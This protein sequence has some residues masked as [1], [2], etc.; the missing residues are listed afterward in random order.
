M[1][2]CLCVYFSYSVSLIHALFKTTDQVKYIFKNYLCSFFFFF[3]L[4]FKM[5]QELSLDFTN[6]FIVFYHSA[7]PSRTELFDGRKLKKEVFY[8]EFWVKKSNQCISI[9]SRI[10]KKS[11]RQETWDKPLL[12]FKK[13]WRISIVF[14]FYYCNYFRY[15][16]SVCN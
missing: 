1:C 13:L 8:E 4:W 11:P 9:I 15:L 5:T 14:I 10:L 6:G 3:L 12:R 16:E 7:I 2:M